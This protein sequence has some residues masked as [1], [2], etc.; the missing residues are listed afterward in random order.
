MEEIKTLCGTKLRNAKY[1]NN[2]VCETIVDARVYE[3]MPVI[4]RARWDL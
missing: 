1:I 3:G 4:V 2:I